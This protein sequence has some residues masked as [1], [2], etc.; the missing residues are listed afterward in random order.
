M[1][2]SN[3]DVD[4][5]FEKWRG[6]PTITIVKKPYDEVFGRTFVIADPDGHLIRVSPLDEEAD[7]YS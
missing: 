6:N 4:C 1:L 3:K 5:L 7:K 2:P